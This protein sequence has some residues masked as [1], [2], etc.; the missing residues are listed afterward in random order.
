MAVYG[1]SAHAPVTAIHQHPGEQRQLQMPQTA[2]AAVARIM[3]LARS[4]NGVISGELIGLTKLEFSP[5]TRLRRSSATEQGR[6][7]GRF[8]KGQTAARRRLAI[9]LHAVVWPA[10]QRVA[11]SWASDIGAISDSVKDRLRCSSANRCARLMCRANLLYSPRNKILATWPSG[12]SLLYEEQTRRG[13]SLRHWDELADVADHCTVC[14]K[15]VNPV[16]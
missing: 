5:T 10:W 13:I 4:L 16:R 15:C 8:S 9:C 3:R 12:R 11:D 2:N 6:P 7:E 1:R 14:H